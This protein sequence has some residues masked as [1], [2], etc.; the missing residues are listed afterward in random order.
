MCNF[1]C[2]S[3]FFDIVFERQDFTA[4]FCDLTK[5]SITDLDTHEDP[6]I[7]IERP[8]FVRATSDYFQLCEGRS[9]LMDKF[10]SILIRLYINLVSEHTS[11]LDVTISEEAL[12][13]GAIYDMGADLMYKFWDRNVSFFNKLFAD[14]SPKDIAKNCFLVKDF[15][16]KMNLNHLIW[17]M[18]H[19]MVD[20]DALQSAEKKNLLRRIIRKTAEYFFELSVKLKNSEIRKYSEKIIEKLDFIFKR[21]ETKITDSMNVAEVFNIL[22]NV[23]ADNDIN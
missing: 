8:S 1:D 23:L 13:L 22:L 21:I 15:F 12:I 20:F 18:E 16:Q 3:Y 5:C 10:T 17:E 4:N 2:P 7:V 19:M 6:P 11:K 9:G 14:I